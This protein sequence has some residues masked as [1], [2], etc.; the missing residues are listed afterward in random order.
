MTSQYLLINRFIGFFPPFSPAHIDN[1]ITR[2]FILI[3]VLLHN[4]T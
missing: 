3:F 2:F 4:T 1:F